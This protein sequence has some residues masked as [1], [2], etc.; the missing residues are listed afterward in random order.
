MH[1]GA[2]RK[3]SHAIEKKSADVKS[4]KMR[5]WV[6]REYNLLQLGLGYAYGCLSCLS[7]VGAGVQGSSEH[8]SKRS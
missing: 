4:Q 5:P 6:C 3:N 1:A 2:M 7:R 8:G